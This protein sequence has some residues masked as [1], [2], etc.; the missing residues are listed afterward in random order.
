[1][2]L[3]TTLSLS[4]YL[5][6][7]VIIFSL[8]SSIQLTIASVTG[9]I[10]SFIVTAWLHFAV[11]E[12]CHE[13]F[14]TGKSLQVSFKTGYRKSL[15]LTIDIF[16]VQFIISLIFTIWGAGAV[17]SFAFVSMISS[18]VGAFTLLLLFRG[19]VKMYLCINSAKAKKVNFVKGE[20]KTNEE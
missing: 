11:I 17:R 9:I 1:M 8:I 6:V 7:S 19:F 4:F 5:I 10:V 15:Q 18:L 13:E 3:L 12:K 14:K 16:A 20:V 2:G